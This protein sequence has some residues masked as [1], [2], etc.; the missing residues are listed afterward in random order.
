MILTKQID[1]GIKILSNCREYVFIYISQC[2]HEYNDN[3]K[4]FIFSSR[5]IS[6]DFKWPSHSSTLY[7]FACCIQSK[8]LTAK[9]PVDNVLDDCCFG[10][11]IQS[12]QHISKQAKFF[13]HKYEYFCIFGH[14]SLISL[15]SLS[16]WL[17][18]YSTLLLTYCTLI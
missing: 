13:L 7:S 3:Q 4:K 16:C 9:I 6:Y 14:A 15:I 5:W 17:A 18:S 12:A 11:W 2:V 1:Y 8:W 10:I